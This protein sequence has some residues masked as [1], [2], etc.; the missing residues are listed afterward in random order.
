MKYMVQFAKNRY[1]DAALK[2]IIFSSIV[3]LLILAAQAIIHRDVLWLNYFNIL[4]LEFF[5]P[6]I[7]QYPL[8][9]FF[10][11]ACAVVIY[12]ILYKYYT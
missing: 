1:I 9:T 11:T 5:F 12:G 8:S 3:H 7:L 6:S 10:A 4:D 2:L